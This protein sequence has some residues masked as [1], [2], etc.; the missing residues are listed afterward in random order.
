VFQPSQPVIWRVAARAQ[1][2]AK[3]FF[4][5]FWQGARTANPTG[6]QRVDPVLLKLLMPTVSNDSR[7]VN[8]NT[9]STTLRPSLSSTLV[10][11]T[12]FAVVA[13]DRPRQPRPIMSV[14]LHD[15]VR[16]PHQR[17]AQQQR[18]AAHSH[19]EP[20]SFSGSIDSHSG[21]N[22][23]HAHSRV[24]SS[25]FTAVDQRPITVLPTL[26]APA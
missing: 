24:P 15:H 11:V 25:V 12:E 5:Q 16:V 3:G 22:A 7:S 14:H 19:S 6:L 10:P 17:C 2:S 1:P 13:P 8:N 26:R 18:L 4:T 23:P 9:S 21:Q 20:V